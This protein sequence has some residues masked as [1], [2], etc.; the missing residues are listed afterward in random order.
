VI[1]REI[2][3]RREEEKTMKDEELE[4]V[5]Q[6]ECVDAP[7]VEAPPVVEPVLLR[8]ELEAQRR[9]LEAEKAAFEREKLVALVERELVSR[10]LAAEF[11]VYLT[12][13]DE[14]ESLAQIEAFEA[15]F[16]ASL[17]RELTR[18]LGSTGAPREPKG[19]RG[20]S[21]ESLRRMSAGEINQHWEEIS[22]TLQK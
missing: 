19:Q 2:R 5:Q 22:R 18:R 20:Y 1:L 3:D 16:Q 17:R 7:E 4:Q 8:D 21:R 13:N 9:A 10:G 6:E 15:L 11:A 14:A 12:G